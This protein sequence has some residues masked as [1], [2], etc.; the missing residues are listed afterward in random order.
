MFKD[1]ELRKVNNVIDQEKEEQLKQSMAETI[2][3]IQKA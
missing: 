2:Q 3:Q 1:K